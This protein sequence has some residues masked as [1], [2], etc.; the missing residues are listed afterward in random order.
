MVIITELPHYRNNILTQASREDSSDG[1]ITVVPIRQAPREAGPHGEQEEKQLQV[2][3]EE[4]GRGTCCCSHG[5]S[6]RESN[7]WW[8]E[9]KQE[10]LPIE[11]V[12]DT[13][14]HGLKVIL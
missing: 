5:S 4:S 7:V 14:L 11:F 8:W 3:A 1:F 6:W 9:P 2:E 13:S 10:R 12:W